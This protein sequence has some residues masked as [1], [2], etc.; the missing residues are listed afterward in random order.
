LNIYNIKFLTTNFSSYLTFYIQVF[1]VRK[2]FTLETTEK[3]AMFDP[4]TKQSL[5]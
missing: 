5:L 3:S 4:H 2:Y 1:F